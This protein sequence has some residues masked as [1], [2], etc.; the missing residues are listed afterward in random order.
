MTRR[1]AITGIGV[2]SPLGIGTDALWHGLR[3]GRSGLG[4]ITR[5]EASALPSRIVGEVPGFDPKDYLDR[6]ERKRLAIMPRPM[7]MAAAG[8]KLALDDA[9]IPAG[10]LDPERF[11]VIF[12]VGTLSDDLSPLGAASH[13]ATDAGTKPLDYAIWGRD[14]LPKIPPRWL[15]NHIPN[16]P[17]SHVSALHDARGPC[18]SIT[19]TELGGLLAMGEAFR[20]IQRDRGDVFLTGG[21]DCRCDSLTL[22]RSTLF[23]PLSRRNDDPTRACRPFDRE[24]D[25][26]VL[27]EGGGV[28]VLEDWD[29]ARRRGAMIHAEVIGFASGFDTQRDGRGLTRV[30]RRALEVAG[31]TSADLDHV[32]ARGSGAIDDDIIEAQGLRDFGPVP[33]LGIRGA[34][35]HTCVAS[36]G[37]ELAASLLAFRH[38]S[39]PPTRNCDHLDPRCPLDVLRE[40]RPVVRDYVLKVSGTECGQ[41]AALVVKAVR[42]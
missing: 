22:T 16:M 40:P 24:R 31:I 14:G 10:S 19:Q 9:H 28:L 23:L 20:M 5:F 7:Q 42:T 11:G 30:I 29:H 8:A 13:L 17:A 15:L 3:D 4:P 34:V 1:V 37:I 36:A 41:W 38:G 6:K 12:G 25:G 35:G 27:A 21:G 26:H 32:N 18:N 39:V 33:V 2:L